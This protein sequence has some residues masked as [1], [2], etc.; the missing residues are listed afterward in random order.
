MTN[1]QKILIVDDNPLMLKTLRDILQI[2]GY[3]VEI[4]VN[5]REALE[6]IKADSFGCVL[7]DVRMPDVSGIELLHAVKKSHPNLPLVL[8]T[9]HSEDDLVQQARAA[10]VTAVL[11]KP[12]NMQS[13]LSLFE[14]FI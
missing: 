8:M 10:G 4:A 11:E 3:R 9:A 12:L 6:K 14:Q 7:S 13:L 2:S 1:P 5:G